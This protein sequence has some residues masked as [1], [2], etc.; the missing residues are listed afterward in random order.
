MN[1][2]FR[3]SVRIAILSKFSLCDQAIGRNLGPST[4]VRRDK[5]VGHR[6]FFLTYVRTIRMYETAK[7]VV[8]AAY[9]RFHKAFDDDLIPSSNTTT[10]LSRLAHLRYT[11]LLVGCN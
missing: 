6:A 9:R 3:L 5:D 10:I 1:N 11:E 7:V 4:C 2:L 8:A